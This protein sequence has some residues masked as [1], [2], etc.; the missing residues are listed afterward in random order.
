MD[1]KKGRF[2][3]HFEVNGAAD[4]YIPCEEVQQLRLLTRRRKAYTERITQYKN[5][6]HNILQRANIKLTI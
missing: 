4:F 6:N 5:E 3:P 1:L 2:F